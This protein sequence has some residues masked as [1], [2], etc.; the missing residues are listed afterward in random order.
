MSCIL[1]ENKTNRTIKGLRTP[2][3][4][5]YCVLL[6]QECNTLF[7]MKHNTAKRMNIPILCLK[8]H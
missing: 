2:K 5:I 4:A 3:R 8:K 7:E 6:P 1:F